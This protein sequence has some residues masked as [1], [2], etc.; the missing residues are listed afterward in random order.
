MAAVPSYLS[1]SDSAMSTRF[2]D[3]ILGYISFGSLKHYLSLS[4]NLDKRVD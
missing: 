2:D 3:T 1:Y 4:K